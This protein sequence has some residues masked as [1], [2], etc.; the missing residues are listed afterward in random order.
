MMSVLLLDPEEMAFKG[1]LN[2][3]CTKCITLDITS[4]DDI[5]N[6]V[7]QYKPRYPSLTAALIEGEIIITASIPEQS[8]HNYL[9]RYEDDGDQGGSSAIRK[10][11]KLT[12]R[13]EG[14]CT[15]WAQKGGVCWAHGASARPKK[16][17]G[18]TC[19]LEACTNNAVEEG[20]VCRKHGGKQKD[21]QRKRVRV[22]PICN[23]EGCTNQVVNGGVCVRHGATTQKCNHEGCT[24]IAIQGGLCVPHG[25]ERKRCNHEGCTKSRGL[26]Q[27]HG[28]T[29]R[30]ICDHDGCTHQAK[31]G[32]LCRTHA[33]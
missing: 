19:N 4:R 18:P 1:L 3:I 2:A 14:G 10:R 30:K 32:G 33:E 22:R 6:I 27:R 28:R 5:Q 12:C 15:K 25:A 8:V 21:S 7:D 29:R 13:H 16:R 17:V 20:G 9:K 26:C 11:P 31:K 23:H 24:N